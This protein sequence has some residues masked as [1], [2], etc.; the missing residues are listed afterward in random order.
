[1]RPL[2]LG[3]LLL[4]LSSAANATTYVVRPDGTGDYPTIQA[5]IDACVDGDVVELTD[6]IFTGDGNR[7]IDYRGKAIT[8]H[9]QTGNPELCVIDCQGTWSDPHRGFDF[10]S[11]EQSSSVLRGITIRNGRTFET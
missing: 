6:G 3:C 9:S 10:H 8:V 1:M 2:T 4:V 7:D 5:A 11:Q